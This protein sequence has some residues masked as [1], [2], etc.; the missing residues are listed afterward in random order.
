MKVIDKLN[1]YIKKKNITIYSLAQQTNIRYELLRRSFAK[2]RRLSADEYIVILKA[3]NLP[4]FDFSNKNS[5]VVNLELKNCDDVKKQLFSLIEK[6]QEA[7][8]LSDGLSSC[9]S[10]MEL[11][12]KI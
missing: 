12:I 1:E 7:K 5:V 3:L 9:I 4:V 2:E 11:E 10:Q 6:M 8:A